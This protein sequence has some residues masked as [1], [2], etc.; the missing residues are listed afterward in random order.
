MAIELYLVKLLVGDEGTPGAPLL[1]LSLAVDAPTGT[2]TGQAEITQAIPPP[3]GDIRINDL[4]GTIEVLP[5]RP[6]PMRIVSLTGTFVHYLPPPQIGQVTEKFSAT[7]LIGEGDWEGF[8]TFVYGR[9][10]VG[11]VPVHQVE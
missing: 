5:L 1:H 3:E 10:K 9:H 7:L 4:R 11:P 6:H 8:G 2:I